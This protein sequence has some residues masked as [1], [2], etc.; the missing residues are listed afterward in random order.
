MK[1][2]ISKFNAQGL[3]VIII[4]VHVMKVYVIAMKAFKYFFCR[5]FKKN[6]L[7]LDQIQVLVLCFPNFM[8]NVIIPIFGR[9]KKKS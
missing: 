4:V 6:H 3:K 5:F 1:C 7:V 9:T 2:E 8:E